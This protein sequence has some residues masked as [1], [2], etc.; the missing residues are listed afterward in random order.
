MAGVFHSYDIRGI[1][2]KEIDVNFAHKLAIAFCEYMPLQTVVI[3]HDERIGSD[4]LAKTLADSFAQQQVQV[5]DI[6]LCTTPMVWFAVNEHKTDGGV[7][8]TASHNPKEFV[9]FKLCKKF[10]IPIGYESG[11]SEIEKRMDSIL[12]N[13]QTRVS[14]IEHAEQE[15]FRS[16]AQ[17][18]IP[19]VTD[20]EQIRVIAD[21]SNSAVAPILVSLFMGT[22]HELTLLNEI[23]DGNF[24][25]H[26]PNPLI[27][28]TTT[29]LSKRVIEEKADFGIIFDGDADRVVFVDEDG[30]RIRPDFIIALLA[31]QL[32]FR[33]LTGKKHPQTP[34]ILA[35]LRVSKV[36]EESIVEN[37]GQLFLTKVGR[38]Y[39]ISQLRATHGLLGGETSGHYYF[40]DFFCC[41]DGV[42][43]LLEMM[44]LIANKQQKLSE[45]VSDLQRYVESGETSLVVR[46][47]QSVL[48]AVK[49]S[50]DSRKPQKISELDGISVYFDTFWF[51]LHVSNTESLLRVNMEANDKATLEREFAA[52]LAIVKQYM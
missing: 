30:T 16:F 8:V 17:S 48:S 29:E 31:Q 36:V 37:G 14:Q 27:E 28:I 18:L 26:E 34:I 12:V 6:G 15:H 49:Q 19:Y 43:T 5:I 35:D 1:F 32:L 21:C 3:G 22:R 9:G 24:P 40:H 50:Y 38:P 7:M 2:G 11:L 25:A 10:A 45:L 20:E 41:D 13:A 44:A 52:L 4:I 51:N 47:A 42:R 46:D 33:K 23:P 39:I